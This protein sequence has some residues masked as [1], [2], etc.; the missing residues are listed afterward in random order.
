MEKIKKF[1][2]I[3]IIPARGGSRRLPRKNILPL[4]GV[5]LMVRVIKT[6]K[7]S[8]IFDQIIVSTEDEEISNIAKK[9]KIKVH[10]RPKK[11]ATNSATVVDTCLDVLSNYPSKM[12]C[13]VYATAA[14]LS[15][16]TLK[17]SFKKFKNDKNTNVLMGVSKYNFSPEQA[18]KIRNDGSAKMLL[19]KYKNQ[20]SEATKKQK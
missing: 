11:L 9:Q 19:P 2:I 10:S 5:P 4:G 8:S 3:A 15:T 13:C 20:N 7:K 12:F 14:L 17:E 1:N 18:L 6:L 16:N